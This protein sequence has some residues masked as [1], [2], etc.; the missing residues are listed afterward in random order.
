MRHSFLVLFFIIS[1]LI[2]QFGCSSVKDAFYIS[3]VGWQQDSI[4]LMMHAKDPAD[5]KGGLPAVT[6]ECYSCNFIVEPITAHFVSPAKSTLL[7]PEAKN[8]LTTRLH[9][10]TGG[11]DTT[12]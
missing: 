10:H 4:Y 11:F 5:A 8:L 1:T 6:A 7:L 12:V 3:T 9:L 2:A